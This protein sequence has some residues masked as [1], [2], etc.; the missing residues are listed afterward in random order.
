MLL[1]ERLEQSIFKLLSITAAVEWQLGAKYIQI[2]I[3]YSCCWMTACSRV[4]LISIHFSCCWMTAWSRVCLIVIYYSCS[5]MTARSRVYFH[6]YLLQLLLN[7]SLEHTLFLI[8]I[9]YS[10]CWMTAWS[11]VYSI[12][13]YY[14]CCWMTAW[15]IVYF[16][17]YLLQL[18]L[19]DSLEQGVFK[20]YLL[21]LLLN[22]S[23]EQYG[24]EESRPAKDRMS[25]SEG[26]QDSNRIHWWITKPVASDFSNAELLV[27]SE[28][29]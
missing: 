1:N 19:N 10:C 14:S 6:R 25:L 15:S 3:Y 9:Y 4:Y 27:S 2:A 26:V 7:D 13:I 20:C 24:G 16:N 5:E 17:Y 28:H 8:V 12:V 18:L 11:R 22:D 23:M 29:S 21:Q